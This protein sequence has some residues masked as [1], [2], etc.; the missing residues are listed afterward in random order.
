MN[1]E[2]PQHLLIN[3]T[4]EDKQYSLIPYVE[5]VA[6]VNILILNAVVGDST[7]GKMTK[8]FLVVDFL[9]MYQILYSLLGVKSFNLTLLTRRDDNNGVYAVSD[10]IEILMGK[11]EANQDGYIYRCK[12]GKTYIDSSLANNEHELRGL[13][14][15]YKIED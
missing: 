7:I 9:D 15:L 2:V 8:M 1:F 13:Q 5:L 10:V 14:T 6:N 11:D 12:S 3:E 4:F